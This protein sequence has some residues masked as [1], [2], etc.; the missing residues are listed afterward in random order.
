MQRLQ[1]DEAFYLY[2]ELSLWHRL[3]RDN[4]NNEVKLG[5]SEA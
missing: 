1:G 5:G 2:L 3:C 4:E